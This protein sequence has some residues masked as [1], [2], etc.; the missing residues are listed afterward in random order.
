MLCCESLEEVSHAPGTSIIARVL[1]E[2]RGVSLTKTKRRLVL[3]TSP[4]FCDPEG[5][6][7]ELGNARSDDRGEI[8]GLP[9]RPRII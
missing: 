5:F 6:N 7:L 4:T 3:L 2:L 8:I 1:E 9:Q